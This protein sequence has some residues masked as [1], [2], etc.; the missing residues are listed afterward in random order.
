MENK[1]IV[2]NDAGREIGYLDYSIEMDMDLGDTNDFAFDMKLVSWDKEKMNYGFIIALPDTEYG[3]MIGDIQSSTGSAKVTLTGETW[4]G[5]LAKKIIEPPA[6]EEYKKVSGELNNILRSLLNGQFGNL[7]FVPQKDTEVSVQNYR[8]KRYCTLLE[9]IE[10]MLS[11]MEYRLDIQYKQG[12]AGVP[13][14]V[15]IQAVPA[16]DFSEQ[17]EYNQDNRINF[18][19]RDYRRGINHLICAGTGEGTDRTVLHLYVQK[20]GTIG[21]NK[22]YKG[23]DERVALYSYTSQSDAEQLRKDGTKRLQEL[24]NYKEFGMK[25]SDVDLNIGDIVSGRDFVTGIL[26]QKP[27]VQKILK[28]QKGKINVEYILKGDE[29]T[30]KS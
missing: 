12:G 23:L 17:K 18:I 3:G 11:S 1:M 8:F 25:V 16:E 19:A 15:E 28:I 6:N 30:W 22:F 24:M 20:D 14:W 29:G 7:F 2:V 13:G 21:G 10:D 27:V 4:R 5:M 9:G 26:V